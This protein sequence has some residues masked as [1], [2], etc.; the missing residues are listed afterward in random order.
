[1]EIHTPASVSVWAAVLTGACP[2]TL[3]VAYSRTGCRVKFSWWR[4]KAR[5]LVL[6]SCFELSSPILNKRVGDKGSDQ[7]R[8]VLMSSRHRGGSHMRT[9]SFVIAVLLAATSALAH[10]SN[11]AFDPDKVVVLKGTVTQWKWTNP[12][13]W[14]F[15]SVDD[16]KGGKA[17]WEIEGRPPACW[18]RRLVEDHLQSR[19]HDH[20]GFQ[21]GEGRQPHRPHHARHARRWDRALER[22]AGAS[23]ITDTER[24]D[25][26]SKTIAGFPR[27]SCAC[28]LDR[29]HRFA[30]RRRRRVRILP[31]C[32]TRSIPMR[33]HAAAPRHRRG[34]GDGGA[35]ATRGGYR[36]ACGPAGDRAEAHDRVPGQMGGHAEVAHGRIV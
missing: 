31:V 17:E 34:A 29:R 5:D 22:A 28:C 30:R 20:R 15:L 18:P 9:C 21:P 35:A 2:N 16:G 32:T 33:P 13:V 27:R 12:H 36:R 24:E 23:V 19:R 14:I 11:S 1:M 26:M 6:A 25:I 4:R 8:P 10:H 7:V 3:W